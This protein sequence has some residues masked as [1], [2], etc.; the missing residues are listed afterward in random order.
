[1]TKYRNEWKF[2]CSDQELA[3]LEQRLSGV[4]K[5]DTHAGNTGLYSVRSLYFDDY[6][7]TSAYQNAAGIANRAK[8]RIRYYGGGTSRHMHLE[9]KKKTN[10]RGKKLSCKLS[11]D[12]CEKIIQGDHL[13]VFWGTDRELLRRFCSEISTKLYRP[14]VII[15]Y[16]RRAYIEPIT[17]IRITFDMNISASYEFDKYTRGK[18]FKI[19]LQE[20]HL[21]VLEVKFD[22]IMPGYIRN[23]INSYGQ[24]QSSFSKYY[25][26]R[27]KLE[28]LI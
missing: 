23:I 11:P 13:E 15:D 20:K 24:Q 8:W 17:N 16:D 10:G 7:N 4:L 3:L 9:Y 19:P 18:Y 25:L 26:G 5:L 1:M 22:D 2:V 21:H 6:D 12:E 14:K 27:K 28:E